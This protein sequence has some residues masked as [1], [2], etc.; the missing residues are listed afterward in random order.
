[1]LPICASLV[2]VP[3]MWHSWEPTNKITIQIL[4]L[5]LCYQLNL[6]DIDRNWSLDQSWCKNGQHGGSDF[7]VIL[8]PESH[9]LSAQLI[10]SLANIWQLLS[11]Y[12]H[13]RD[14]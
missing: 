14:P 5:Q 4:G 12:F 3:L 9:L 7:S 8:V 6:L 1:M 10:P 13:S 11:L 2:N